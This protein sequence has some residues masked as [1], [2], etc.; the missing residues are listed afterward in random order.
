MDGGRS[1]RMHGCEW[2]NGWMH[3]RGMDGNMDMNAFTSA[4][5]AVWMDVRQW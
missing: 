5:M 3:G 2:M 1:G 4:C